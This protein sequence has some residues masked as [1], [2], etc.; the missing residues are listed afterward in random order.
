M[1]TLDVYQVYNLFTIFRNFLL[2][3]SDIWTKWKM[4][5]RYSETVD[6]IF[7][8]FRQRGQLFTI[9]RLSGITINDISISCIT[10]LRYFNNVDTICS[11]FSQRIQ[12][13]YAISTS[14][15]Y[16]NTL[17]QYHIY[18]IPK[19]RRTYFRYF[20]KVGNIFR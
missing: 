19:S 8:T 4:Y 3:F 7:T 12:P 17:I 16:S 5:I 1:D 14:S 18:D 20:D 10:C 9:F 11:I 2:H 6:N 13:N 15:N